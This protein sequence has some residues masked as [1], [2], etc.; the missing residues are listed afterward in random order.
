MARTRPEPWKSFADWLTAHRGLTPATVSTYLTQVRRM[1]ADVQPLA[2]EGL[3]GWVDALPTHHRS[4]H[5]TAWRC[6]V[7]WRASEGETVPDLILPEPAVDV[8]GDV[9][10]AVGVL[11][12]GSHL[13]PRDL[14]LLTWQSRVANE[15]RERA[16]PDKVFFRAPEGVRADYALLD[17]E[18]LT[19]VTRWAYGAE[20]PPCDGPLLPRS[21]GEVAAMLPTT[22]QRLLRERRR[23]A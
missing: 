11:L 16:F 5:R 13:K 17:R 14:A 9:L 6:Y 21:P 7:A 4:P 10:D 15:V 2:S 18:A 12:T 23:V 8:P 20:V 3:A 22:I 1:L 19:T